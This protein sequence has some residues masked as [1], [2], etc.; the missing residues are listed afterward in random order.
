MSEDI[1]ADHW[2]KVD[3]EGWDKISPYFSPKELACKSDGSLKVRTDALK[4]LNHLRKEFGGP[5]KV[6]SAYRTPAHNKAVGGSPKSQHVEGIAFDLAIKD[7]AT[8]LKIEKIAKRIG[9]KGIGRYDTFIHV[10]ARS[11][12]AEWG[13]W[14]VVNTSTLTS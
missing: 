11:T 7:H 4:L 10:D 12:P 8:G 14:N 9:M 5:L 3:K 6:N 1:E 2:S 13:K